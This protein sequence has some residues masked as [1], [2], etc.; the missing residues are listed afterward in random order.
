LLLLRWRCFVV[1]VDIVAVNIAVAFNIVVAR[2]N[3]SFD[4]TLASDCVDTHYYC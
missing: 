4:Y 3:S 2:D 1:V